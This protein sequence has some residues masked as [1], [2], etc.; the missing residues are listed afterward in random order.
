M[1]TRGGNEEA[2]RWTALKHRTYTAPHWRSEDVPSPAYSGVKRNRRHVELPCITALGAVAHGRVWTI[3]A[4]PNTPHTW[5]TA[6]LLKEERKGRTRAKL[7][8]EW[9]QVRRLCRL[10]ENPG[11][12][13]TRPAGQRRG[14]MAQGINEA[15]LVGVRVPVSQLDDPKKTPDMLIH[16]RLPT[17]VANRS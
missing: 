3:A 14:E 13:H 9:E 6:K 12:P 5:P 4:I 17:V 15:M 7:T 16:D 11:R 10:E 1:A 8:S 2:R